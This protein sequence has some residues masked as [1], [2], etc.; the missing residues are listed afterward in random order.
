MADQAITAPQPVHLPVQARHPEKDPKAA[1]PSAVSK[2]AADA[3]STYLRAPSESK[4]LARADKTDAPARH[5][6]S[7][8]V[9]W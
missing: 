5:R 8:L 4:L 2:P 9:I 3:A 6:N 1:P 7:D